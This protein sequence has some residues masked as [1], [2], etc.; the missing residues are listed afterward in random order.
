[1][2]PPSL[3]GLA[4]SKQVFHPRG[5]VGSFFAS[6]IALFFLLGLIVA[7]YSSSDS[8]LT[9]LTTSFSL[10]ILE[11]DKKKSKEDQ[12]KI[13]KR[14][15]ISFSL[16]LIVT[17]L[18]F[19]YFI[20]DESVISKIFQFAGY[21]YGPLLGLYAFGLFTKLNVKDKIVPIVAIISP[22]LTIIISFY[23]KKLF[24]F[25]FGFFVLV[26]NGFLTFIG[27]LIISKKD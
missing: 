22:I 21:T 3:I 6:E 25:D 9:S 23:S 11:I 26:L 18:I 24:A 10:D 27:L 13:R 20:A 16:V 15:H 1:M 17:I 2:L 14:V 19:K 12:I 7:A 5:S 8:A 4:I